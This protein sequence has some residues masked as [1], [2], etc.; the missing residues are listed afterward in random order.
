MSKITEM[1]SKKKSQKIDK[2][3]TKILLIYRK[4]T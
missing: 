2:T 3:D 1:L 4:K